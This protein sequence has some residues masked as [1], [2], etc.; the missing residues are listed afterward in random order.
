MKK[1]E[2]INLLTEKGVKESNLKTFYNKNRRLHTWSYEKIRQWLREKKRQESIKE[3]RQREK[4]DAKS[5]NMSA[6]EYKSLREKA[7]KILS[8]FDTG[9][10]MGCYKTLYVNGKPFLRVSDTQEYAKS[11]KYKPTYGSLGINLN[12]KQLREVVKIQGVWTVKTG[13]HTCLTIE[14]KG[15]KHTYE[16]NLIS[17]YIFGESHGETF[18]QAKENHISKR[19]AK[20]EYYKG[21]TEQKDLNKRFVG[22]DHLRKN[23]A[24][25]SGILAFCRKHDLNPEWGYN[26]GYLRSLENNS[27]LKHINI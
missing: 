15:N 9:H 7:E 20:I 10:S 11:C 16:V 21:I 19:K 18:E 6:K 24:C 14:D 26:V 17:G 3:R 12:K 27:F 25:K 1:Q 2:I 22:F 13:K 23:G 5:F 8:D 4:G